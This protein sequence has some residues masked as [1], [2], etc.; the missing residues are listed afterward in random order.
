MPEKEI[1]CIN[2]GVRL[3]EMANYYICRSCKQ[4]W[5]ISIYD[6][7][8]AGSEMFIDLQD[9]EDSLFM[10]LFDELNIHSESIE[11]QHAINKAIDKNKLSINL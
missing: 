10:W 4:L 9:S 8:K 7:F 2:C 3:I 11:V 6:K 1:Y 5:P